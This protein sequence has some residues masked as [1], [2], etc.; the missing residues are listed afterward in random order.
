MVLGRDE[1]P[2]LSIMLKSERRPENLHF[3][4]LPAIAKQ[5]KSLDLDNELPP[6][7]LQVRVESKL[8]DGTSAEIVTVTRIEFYEKGGKK[9][10]IE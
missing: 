6:A 4:T 8:L 5:V 9:K 1:A 2:E 10:V 3:T 7:L